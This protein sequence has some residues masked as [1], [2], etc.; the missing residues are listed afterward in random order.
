[1]ILDLSNEH[2]LYTSGCYRL[3][4]LKANITFGS[5]MTSHYI[6]KKTGLKQKEIDA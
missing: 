3:L 5:T 6:G 2:S 4:A 1:M